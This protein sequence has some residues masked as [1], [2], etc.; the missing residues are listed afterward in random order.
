MSDFNQDMLGEMA[1]EALERTAFVSAEPADKEFLD[2]LEPCEWYTRIR[3]T[4][5]VNGTVYLAGSAG[6]MLGL[7]SSLL[8][9]EVEEG[10]TREQ[11]CA[12]DFQRIVHPEELLRRGGRVARLRAGGL[13]LDPLFGFLTLVGRERLPTENRK[14]R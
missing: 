12:A 9:V 6:F 7:A 10:L 8:G 13:E 5:P 4:G 14:R 11:V 1:I 3:Y 2:E